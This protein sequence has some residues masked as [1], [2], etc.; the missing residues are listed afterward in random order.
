[1]QAVAVATRTIGKMASEP[2]GPA[3]GAEMGGKRTITGTRMALSSQQ[4]DG[5]TRANPNSSQ[6][7][8]Q[9]KIGD[10]VARVRP[11]PDEAVLVHVAGLTRQGFGQRRGNR[12][13]IAHSVNAR[14]ALKRRC[15]EIHKRLIA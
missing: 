6:A 3:M 1:M 2:L 13:Q 15:V 14:L 5:R 12:D 9:S 11:T 8:N 10:M 4:D 7:D